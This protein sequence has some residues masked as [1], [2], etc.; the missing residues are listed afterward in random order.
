LRSCWT[1]LRVCASVVELMAGLGL[2]D[3]ITRS[4]PS[5]NR[6]DA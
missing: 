4:D 6:P 5:R 2:D 3:R 1:M